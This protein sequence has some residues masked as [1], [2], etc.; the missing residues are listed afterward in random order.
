M[1][2]SFKKQEFVSPESA[3][4]KKKREITIGHV[5]VNFWLIF[6]AVI[7]VIPMIWLIFAPSK[8]DRGISYR[9]PL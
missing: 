2:I 8:T 4:R 5:A 7:S 1:S 3:R 9:N 6:W